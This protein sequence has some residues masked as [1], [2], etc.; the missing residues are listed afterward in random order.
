VTQNIG[1]VLHG[2]AVAEQAARDA[3]TK[4]VR[5]S[6][7][8]PA[9]CESRDYRML[10]DA[11]PDRDVIRRD[12]ANEDRA[13]VGLRSF[14]AQ[15][16]CD[17]VAGGHRQW[18]AIGK[19]RLGPGYPND[20]VPPVYVVEPK[21]YDLGASEPKVGDASHHRICA[22]PGGQMIVE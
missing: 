14:M 4:D 9:P 11:S 20:P 19:M 16:I 3:V 7:I 10:G 1:D 22:S 13:V 21:L 6:P 2:R 17:R 18:K 8:P 5:I 12:M 15:I